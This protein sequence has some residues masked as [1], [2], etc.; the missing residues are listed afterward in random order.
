MI[1]PYP[2]LNDRSCG[3][4]KFV[5]RKATTDDDWSIS[6]NPH[7]WWDQYS[8]PPMTNYPRF[9]LADSAYAV[10]LM[11]EKTPAWREVYTRILDGLVSRH[12]TFWA[13]ADWLTQIG[14]DPKRKEYPDAWKGFLIP[15]HLWGEYDS[16]GWTANGVAPWGL[17]PDPISADGMLFFKGFFNLLMS[18]YRAVSGDRKWEEPFTITGLEDR[19]FE[20]THSRIADLL[21]DQWRRHPEGPHCENTK[22][23]P[24]CLSAAGLGLQLF[25][26]VMS[27]NN[28]AVAEE[29][30]EYAR[31]HYLKFEDGELRSVALYYD[32]IVDHVHHIGTAGGLAA[33]WYVLPQNPQMAELMYRAAMADLGWRDPKQPIIRQPDPRVLVAAAAMAREFGDSIAEARLRDSLDGLAEPKHFGVDHAEFGF[34]FQ[35]DEPWPRGQMSASLMVTEVADAGDWQRL[36]NLP[37]LDKFNQPTVEGV[38]FP[39]LGLSQAWNDLD[40]GMLQITTYAATPSL[41][42]A[43]TT[44]KVSRLPNVG[45]VYVRCDGESF[46]HWQAGDDGS[47]EI[48]TDIDRHSFQIYTGLMRGPLQQD[49]ETF[50]PRRVLGPSRS[51]ELGA[52]TLSA[53]RGHLA[54]GASPCPT[55]AC[56]GTTR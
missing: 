8:S 7:P 11:A 15:E 25:D 4:L 5:W 46:E 20:W 22:I 14:H 33:A 53:A 29:W 10:S 6:G 52:E 42:G 26:R 19:R 40:N 23:W 17:Q 27:K 54:S 34:W 21:V 13:A 38:D 56:A 12:T 43:S 30:F 39:K 1:S 35:F 48:F 49:R 47:I 45:S 44:I 51:L 55:C 18:L 32:P 16:P 37:N 36:F 3:W 2:Q 41:R 50:R 24:Y 9:D 31:K 28:H